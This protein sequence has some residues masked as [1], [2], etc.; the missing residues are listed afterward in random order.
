MTAQ[1]L[2]KSVNKNN[3]IE[4]YIDYAGHPKNK[5]TRKMV[6][7][8]YD[9]LV[10]AD[11]T[12]DDNKI[13]FSVKCAGEVT[14]DTFMVVRDTLEEDRPEH[15]G[16]DF[17]DPIE[18]LGYSIS[19]ACRHYINYDIQYAAAIFYELSFFGYSLSSQKK[20]QSSLMDDINKA[21][22]EIENGAAKFSTLKE[23]WDKLDYKD[24]RSEPE[25]IFDDKEMEL[26]GEYQTRIRRELY[27]LEMN[28]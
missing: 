26:D 11:V 22:E 14:L 1:E 7:N 5:R 16:L 23:M 18:V 24:P 2:L 10:K 25:K 6:S 19:K 15:Y 4:Y 3:F 9:Q 28:Y 12:P 17:E 8:Y 13:I 20:R 21:V 27:N